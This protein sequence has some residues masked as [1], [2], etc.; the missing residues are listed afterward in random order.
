MLF[1]M[2]SCFASNSKSPHIIIESDASI[3]VG[4]TKN[5]AHRPWKLLNDLN[6]IDI[7]LDEVDCIAVIHIN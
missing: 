4:W 5:K 1:S 2:H 3:A 7:L 6:L